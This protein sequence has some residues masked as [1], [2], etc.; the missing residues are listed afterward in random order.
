MSFTLAM[1]L[2][3]ALIKYGPSVWSAVE[4]LEKILTA[5][6]NE[7]GSAAAT[8]RLSPERTAAIKA[9]VPDYFADDPSYW[10]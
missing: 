6:A 7:H 3:A 9:A 2:V 10:N 1:Q 8:T 5:H 4:A